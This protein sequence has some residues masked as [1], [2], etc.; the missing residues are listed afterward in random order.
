MAKYTL[1]SK[2]EIGDEVF[3]I[4][5]EKDES[6]RRI[7]RGYVVGVKGDFSSEYKDGEEKMR[8]TSIY[9]DV[10]LK[11]HPETTVWASESDIIP[12]EGNEM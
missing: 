8:Y 10:T 5:K 7:K 1:E 4:T 2:F 12:L 11:M 3:V 6:Q 9:Y